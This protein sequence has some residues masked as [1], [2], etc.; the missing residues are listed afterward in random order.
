MLRTIINSI[1]DLTGGAV[2]S[3]RIYPHLSWNDFVVVRLLRHWVSARV[4]QENAMSGLVALARDLG[5]DEQVAIALESVFQLTEQCL[6]RP[7]D[8]ECCCSKSVSADE[9]AILALIASAPRGGLPHSPR[10]LPHGLPGALCWAVAATRLALRTPARHSLDP[11][12]SC[13]FNRRD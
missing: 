2:Q 6:G 10:H 8:A 4:M 7:L 5:E 12:I 3:T 9:G 11:T 13:P 1:T